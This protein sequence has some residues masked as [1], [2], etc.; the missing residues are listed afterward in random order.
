MKMEL[1]TERP[2]LVIRRMM[3]EPG[4]AMFWHTD[5]CRRFS[6]VVQGS[7]LRIEHR[8][9]Q[10]TID[11]DVHPGMA[12]WDDPDDRVHRAVN[13]GADRYEEVVTFFRESAD[14]VPQPRR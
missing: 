9:S 1:L 4:E 7:R 12:D 5:N 11:I 10:E 13:I 8:D 2:E 6:V 3:L 14:V